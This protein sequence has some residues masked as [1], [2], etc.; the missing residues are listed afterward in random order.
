M[1]IG[2][3]QRSVDGFSSL[4]VTVR[5]STI[6]EGRRATVWNDNVGDLRGLDVY[7]KMLAR[8]TR[9]H[10]RI[11]RQDN[12]TSD[13]VRLNNRLVDID[14]LTNGLSDENTLVLRDDGDVSWSEAPDRRTVHRFWLNRHTRGQGRRRQYRIRLG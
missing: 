2:V 8:A 3:R 5:V 10:L 9:D 14:L 11:P 12:G 13:C 1:F 4:A 7:Q 6:Y